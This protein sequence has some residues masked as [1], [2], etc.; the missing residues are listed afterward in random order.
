MNFLCSSK[1]LL[2]WYLCF[3]VLHAVDFI[4][5]TQVFRTLMKMLNVLGTTFQNKQKTLSSI[6]FVIHSCPN[7]NASKIQI[8]QWI[9]LNLL[10]SLVGKVLITLGSWS[11]EKFPFGKFSDNS[12]IIDHMTYPLWNQNTITFHYSSHLNL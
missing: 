3:L 2:K 1:L 10:M 6:N 7:D 8:T 11:K 4:Q 12:Y 9:F 5:V